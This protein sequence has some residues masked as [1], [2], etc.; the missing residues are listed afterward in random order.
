M[1]VG[2]DRLFAPAAFS[3]FLLF[4]LLY[5]LPFCT[6]AQT[7]DF[8]T[9]TTTM[10]RD[11][12]FNREIN[13]FNPF[14]TMYVLADFHDLKPGTYNLLTDWQ[15]PWGSLEHQ[16]IHTFVIEKITP[17]YKVFS[18][19]RL[20]K[21]GPFKRAVTGEE[22]KKEFYGMWEVVLYLNGNQVAKNI[23]EVR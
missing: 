23:F 1:M 2:T 18:W 8:A 5:S 16:S 15:S 13:A 3:L 12:S 6:P 4:F 21:N 7:A 10:H 11:K 9:I 22:Y 14:D 20:W 19:L 17:S